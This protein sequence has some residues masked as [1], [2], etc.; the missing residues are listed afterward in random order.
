[1]KQGLLTVFC[2][3]VFGCGVD[4]NGIGHSESKAEYKWDEWFAGKMI[5]IVDDS[6]AV[7]D[8]YKPYCK[9]WYKHSISGQYI[10]TECADFR[11]GLF[12]INYREKQKPVW[13]DTLNSNSI[14]A[15]GYFKDNS[16]LVFDRKDNKFGFWKIGTNAIE[17]IDYADFG[18]YESKE[19]RLYIYYHARPWTDGNILL[20]YKRYGYYGD[21]KLLLLDVG[22]RQLKPFEF[23]GEYEWLSSCANGYGSKGRDT[24]IDYMNISHIG[25][26]IS[27]IKKNYAPSDSITFKLPEN[28][29][30]ELTVNG[31]VTDT[32]AISEASRGTSW[33]GNY[34]MA[35]LTGKI[36]KIDTLNFK[37]DSTYIPVLLTNYYSVQDL[38]GFFD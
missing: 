31:T 25:G 16:V 10:E 1:M 24:I 29:L 3:I 35:N 8:I 15:G 28:N 5:S 12:L 21:S 34:V 36:Y 20:P 27:C 22:N 33:H 30:F 9:K 23:S 6:L 4:E 19:E 37:F 2:A 38:L 17:F 11:I 26:K 18:S 13:G 7:V 14:I 32:L